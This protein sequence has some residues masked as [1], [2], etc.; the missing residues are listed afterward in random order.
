VLRIIHGLTNR[1]IAELEGLPAA[2]VGTWLRRG[3]DELQRNL[4]PVLR[5]F[6]R[7]VRWGGR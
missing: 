7:D 4:R 5:E 1:E 2:T 6:G 3:R